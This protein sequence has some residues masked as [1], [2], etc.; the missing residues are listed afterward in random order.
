MYNVPV[1]QPKNTTMSNPTFT[2]TEN[3]T[4]NIVNTLLA[5]F[6]ITTDTDAK[7]FVE[8][9]A[10]MEFDFNGEVVTLKAERTSEELYFSSKSLTQTEVDSVVA[11]VVELSRPSALG[12]SFGT[13][14]AQARIL[15][16]R[17]ED[18]KLVFV[19][20]PEFNEVK[21]V[22]D[23]IVVEGVKHIELWMGCGCAIYAR[24]KNGA[25]DITGVEI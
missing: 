2:S 10:I 22:I 16:H 4:T 3:T 17:V 18:G 14:D 1:N 24:T 19:V 20:S 21:E 7:C 9:F 15:N 11:K 12:A 13:K 23:S 25:F 5:G 6:G 8:Q